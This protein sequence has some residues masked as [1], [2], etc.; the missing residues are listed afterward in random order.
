MRNMLDVLFLIYFVLLMVALVGAFWGA[1][2][3]SIKPF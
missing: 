1:D 2:D 3:E